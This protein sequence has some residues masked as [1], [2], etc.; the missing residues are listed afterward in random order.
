MQI[1]SLGT[2]L[3]TARLHKTFLPMPAVTKKATK[4]KQNKRTTKA[5]VL[6]DK[7]SNILG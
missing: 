7:Y 5:N 3:S 1:H 6:S 4:T 2:I